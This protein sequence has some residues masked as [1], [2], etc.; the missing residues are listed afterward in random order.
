MV[1]ISSLQT[2]INSGATCIVIPNGTYTHLSGF[3]V[4]AGN[5]ITVEAATPGYV[6][7]TDCNLS[8]GITGNNCTIMNLQF[9]NTSAYL[10][11]KLPISAKG[12]SANDLIS[13]SGC[14]NTITGLNIDNVYARHF[15]HVYGT[16]QDTEISHTNIEDK[17]M[18]ADNIAGTALINS[19]IELQGSPTVTSHHW[20]HHCT[21]QNM[22]DEN[23][24]N[25]GCP[26][27]RIGDGQCSTNNL[28]TIVEY[29]VFDDVVSAGKEVIS[30][31]SMNNVIRYNT[32]SNNQGSY[33]S[34]R[35]GNH[36]VCYGNFFLSAS[37]IRFM[38]ASHIS[39][40]NNYFENCTQCCEWVLLATLYTQLTNYQKYHNHIQVQNNTFYNCAPICIDVYDNSGNCFAN[41]LLVR[42]GNMQ[43]SNPTGHLPLMM[44]NLSSDC[45][46]N[47]NQFTVTGNMYAGGAIQVNNLTGFIAQDP[48]LERNQ[49]GYCNINATSRAV[50]QATKLTVPLLSISNV[51]TDHLLQLD[52]TGAVRVP[53]S[54]GNMDVGCYQDRVSGTAFNLPLTASMVGPS[55][56]E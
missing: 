16:A 35:H 53:N 2:A 18:N 31:Q 40:Y 54:A 22:T 44:G 25:H 30:I 20:V 56:L 3:V 10:G 14:N 19:M 33:I 34:F 29:C 24:S 27:I 39:V 21:F 48:L 37:G 5:N 46:G 15:I 11:T 52:I 36:N 4:I 43:L 12:F 7:F 8:F 42:D 28:H 9:V 1:T 50:G 41:N 17:P 38:Q 6:L 47:I 45:S 26:L 49:Q 55:Y 23:N 51:T 13:I 32:F